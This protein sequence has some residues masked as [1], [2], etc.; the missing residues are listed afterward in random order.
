MIHW[1]CSNCR[2]PREICTGLGSI[3]KDPKQIAKYQDQTTEDTSFLLRPYNTSGNAAGGCPG[4]A[5]F[6]NSM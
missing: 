6:S 4:P 2:L 5:C 1:W 3:E